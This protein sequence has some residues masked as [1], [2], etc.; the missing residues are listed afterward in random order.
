MLK[1]AI[2]QPPGLDGLAQQ[3]GALLRP[4][5]EVAEFLTYLHTD[6]R[7]ER[8][9]R[10]DKL[11]SAGKIA[12]RINGQL[13][14]LRD[15]LNEDASHLNFSFDSLRHIVEPGNPVVIN[16]HPRFDA[17]LISRKPTDACYFLDLHFNDR[18]RLSDQN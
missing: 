15:Y 18:G 10:E 11:P 1:R 4:L 6:D 7:A 14:F 2:S 3:S 5:V 16:T 9:F 12:K 17:V 8:E 13:K